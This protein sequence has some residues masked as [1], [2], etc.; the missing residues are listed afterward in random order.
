M[1]KGINTSSR[2]IAP[3]AASAAFLLAAL[4]ADGRVATSIDQHLLKEAR[5]EDA[6]VISECRDTVRCVLAQIS[7]AV[8]SKFPGLREVDYELTG[9]TIPL[10]NEEFKVGHHEDIGFVLVGSDGLYFLAG[11][12]LN[13][14]IANVE[15]ALGHSD[16]LRNDVGQTLASTK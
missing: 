10:G 6:K 8:Q 7:I 16:E 1:K 15:L 5:A 3:V 4:G 14:T 2:L 9:D 13:N 12:N 11:N